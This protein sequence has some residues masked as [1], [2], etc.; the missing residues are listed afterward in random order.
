MIPVRAESS[1]SGEDGM[2]GEEILALLKFSGPVVGVASAVWSTTQK[3]TYERAD[4]AKR[5]TLQG[6]VMVGIIIVSGLISVLALGLELIVHEQLAA[7]ERQADEKRE[8]DRQAKDQAEALANLQRDAAQQ[9]RFLEQRFQIA[10]AEAE[11]QRR[12]AQISL[13][14]AREA[15]QRL[16]EAERTF[17]EFD[18]INYPLREVTA[19]VELKL[20]LGELGPNAGV[21][22][23]WALAEERWKKIEGHEHNSRLLLRDE[24]LMAVGFGG[25]KLFEATHRT[26]FRLDFVPA[27]GPSP[28]PGQHRIARVSPRG[29]SGSHPRSL[30]LSFKGIIANM[31]NP[32]TLTATYSYTLEPAVEGE[33]WRG[34][35]LSLSDINR[36]V[37]ILT[38]TRYGAAGRAPDTLQRV[39]YTL[40]EATRFD[41]R[42]NLAIDGNATF[43]L[44]PP[45]VR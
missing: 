29:G 32:R 45:D 21:D 6:R 33:I 43:V 19:W 4:G 25:T 13:Q 2:T 9:K 7:K 37:P 20:E 42:P 39:W 27:D 3:I 17:A 35:K 8:Q 15:N 34:E 23:V 24:D 11:Q 31:S 30:S 18:R 16:S 14:I 12:D 40:N 5:L 28:P 44:Y 22:K 1:A 26:D 36:L 38:I 41:T 10:A